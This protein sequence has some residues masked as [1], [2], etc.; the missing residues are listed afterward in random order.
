MKKYKMPNP[1]IQGWMT[2]PE[3][4]WLYSTASTM[5]SIVEI[6]SWKGRSIHALLEGCKH[7]KV[8][9]VDTFQGSPS[10]L[11]SDHKEARSGCI[12][13]TFNANTEKYKNLKCFPMHSIEAIK[14][15]GTEKFDMVFIDAE[16]TYD[17]VISDLTAWYFR[18]SKLLCGHDYS[19]ETVQKALKDFGLPLNSIELP[20]GSI[21][22]YKM[23]E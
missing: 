3:L 17:S 1:E 2:V 15:T 6:G 14:Y 20:A 23:P 16:H 12:F 21:W 9:A 4:E 22:A 5:D 11:D 19:Y 13:R 7:G 8:I 10:E 18:C